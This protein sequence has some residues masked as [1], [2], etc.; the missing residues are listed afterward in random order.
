[1]NR[2]YFIKNCKV[3]VRDGEFYRW[4]NRQKDYIP[5]KPVA[6]TTKHPYGKD[7]TYIMV[8]FYD[9]IEKKG[10]TIPY[11]RFLYIWEFGE[12]PPHYDVDHID[13]NALNNDIK[14]LQILSRRENLLR[15]GGKRN[16]YV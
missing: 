1:M 4:S 16:Q 11:H 6:N 9:I 14:N 8:S 15:R 10:F 2:D 13:G 5:L 7:K 12:I 3:I